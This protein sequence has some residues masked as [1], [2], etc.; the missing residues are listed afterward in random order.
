MHHVLRKIVRLQVV[1]ILREHVPNRQ[2][3]SFPFIDP[4]FTQG[5]QCLIRS[6][7][8]LDLDSAIDLKHDF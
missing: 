6:R 5:L 4:L 8:S 3:E 7:C 2:H 1:V